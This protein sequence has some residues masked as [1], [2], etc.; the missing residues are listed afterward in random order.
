MKSRETLIRLKKFAVDE[1]R[2]KA[3]QIES[4]IADFDRMAGDLEREIKTEQDRANI[5]DPSH[6]AYPTY[7]KAAATRRENLK[8][9]T[10]ELRIQLEDAKSAL[11]EAFEELKKVEMLDQRD[12]ARELAEANSREQAELDSIGAMRF[13]AARA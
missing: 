12:Q 3:A 9:S 4:M 13:H 7:A 8:R 5:H 10:D 2:R 6:F 11:A 1:K